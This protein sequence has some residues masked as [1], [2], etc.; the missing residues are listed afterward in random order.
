MEIQPQGSPTS[1]SCRC[2]LPTTS[3]DQ[4]F[5]PSIP[6]K[7]HQQP[8]RRSSKQFSP[9]A[10]SVHI[11]GGASSLHCINQDTTAPPEQNTA[12][13]GTS[14]LQPVH[15]T[16]PGGASPLHTV[17]QDRNPGRVSLRQY[18]SRQPR[19]PSPPSAPL[20][21][22]TEQ[23]PNSATSRIPREELPPTVIP[24]PEG[25]PTDDGEDRPQIPSDPQHPETPGKWF[26][27]SQYRRAPVR[28]RTPSPSPQQRHRLP[29]GGG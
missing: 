14:S 28:E 29:Q 25:S 27:S 26:Q 18:K 15:N 5:P 12:L 10:H 13:G 4:P 7:P 22:S 24:I 8:R 11:P 20:C 3:Q 21:L 2:D 23:E 17:D 16:K 19:S 6:E 1:C 9:T